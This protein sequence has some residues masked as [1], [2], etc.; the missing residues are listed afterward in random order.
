MLW[1]GAG[2]GPSG[3]SPFLSSRLPPELVLEVGGDLGFFSTPKSGRCL[4]RTPV[5]SVFPAPALHL[6]SKPRE[7]WGQQRGAVA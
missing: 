4:G 6:A 3:T 7:A 1:G 2:A 5:T